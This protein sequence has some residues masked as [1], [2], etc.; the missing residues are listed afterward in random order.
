MIFS[1]WNIRLNADIGYNHF[2]GNYQNILI[3]KKTITQGINIISNFIISKK[4]GIYLTVPLSNNIQ[5]YSQNILVKNQFVAN[6]WFRKILFAGNGSLN[7][8][9]SDVFKS[10]KDR[11]HTELSNANFDESYYYGNSVIS[12]LFNYKFGKKTIKSQ[13]NRVTS[14]NEEKNRLTK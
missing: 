3:D 12:V 8:G 14:N 5:H 7:L 2:K 11:Y 4:R 9:I 6:I 10:S 13:R 1:F